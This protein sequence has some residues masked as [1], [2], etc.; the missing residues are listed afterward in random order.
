MGN[1]KFSVV[2]F[3]GTLL[4]MSAV[5]A[6]KGVQIAWKRRIDNPFLEASGGRA[7]A[8]GLSLLVVGLAG[9]ALAVVE[10]MK[11]R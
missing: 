1:Q 5:A 10:G 7:L 2:W 4:V 8:I 9:F 6:W 11:L 3:A